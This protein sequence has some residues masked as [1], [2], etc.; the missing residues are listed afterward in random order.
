MTSNEKIVKRFYDKFTTSES[1]CWLWTSATW[2]RMGYGCMWVSG[3][4]KTAHRLSWEIHRGEIQKD[5][6]VLHKC[7]NPICVNPDHLF[8]GTSADNSADMSLKGRSLYC[9]KNP[10]RKLD[11]GIVR[12]MRLEY[13]GRRGEIAAIATKY[14]TDY[15]TTRLAVT[16]RTWSRL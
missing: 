14:N 4:T 5:K 15:W 7:D 10:A 1:G 12:A 3:K 13:S 2:G 6:K 8:L 11:T 16:G 9:E